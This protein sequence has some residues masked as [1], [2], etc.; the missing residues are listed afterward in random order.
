MFALSRICFLILSFYTADENILEEP[1]VTAG[2]TC[3][4]LK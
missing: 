3:V 2:K 4:Y 1:I